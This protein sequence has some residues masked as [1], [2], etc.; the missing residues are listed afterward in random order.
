MRKS[1]SIG[2]FVLMLLCCLSGCT[3]LNEQAFMGTQG[4]TLQL[5]QSKDLVRDVVV[6]TLTEKGFQTQFSGNIIKG[7]K[8]IQDGNKTISINMDCSLLDNPRG[9]TLLQASAMKEIYKS[10]SHVKVF[11]LIFIPIP[12]GTYTTGAVVA[13]DTIYDKEFY[14][15]FFN[16]VQR[17]AADVAASVT[18]APVAQPAQPLIA[19]PAL[20]QVPTAST[21]VASQPAAA[22]PQPIAPP[23]VTSPQTASPSQ[24][25]A[26][27]PQ[28]AAVPAPT[29]PAPAAPAS[30]NAV[31]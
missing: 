20:S 12:Y 9:G 13:A 30:A 2:G 26:P 25:A 3:S 23:A 22:S 17:K 29:S 31:Q 6:S 7:T 4:N 21:P 11:W 27:A 10:S 1:L 18:V 14:A 28:S 24:T 15:T 8:K 5:V 19:A 16:E